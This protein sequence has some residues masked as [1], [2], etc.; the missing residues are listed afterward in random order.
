MTDNVL[1]LFVKDTISSSFTGII[2]SMFPLKS[3]YDSSHIQPDL[4]WHF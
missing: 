4:I 1:V 2:M 3:Y